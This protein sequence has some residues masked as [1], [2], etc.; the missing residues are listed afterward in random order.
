MGILKTELGERDTY[1]DYDFEDVMFRFEA[2]T[3]K[4]FRRFYG[5][6]NESEVP[7]DNRLLNDALLFGDETNAIEYGSCARRKRS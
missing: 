4:F 1:V 6:S 5:E 7:P 2:K 3:E